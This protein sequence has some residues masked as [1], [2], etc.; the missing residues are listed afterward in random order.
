MHTVTSETIFN[1]Q[2][3]KYLNEIGKCSKCFNQ[4]LK[5]LT[6]DRQ[7]SLMR[8]QLKKSEGIKR[9]R[10]LSGKSKNNFLHS[11][12]HNSIS[13]QLSSRNYD[14]SISKSPHLKSTKSKKKIVSRSKAVSP[15]QPGV[16]TSKIALENYHS[17]ECKGH[18]TSKNS[19]TNTQP[20]QPRQ[21]VAKNG[22]TRNKQFLV[23]TCPTTSL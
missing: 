16:V 6:K 2:E 9:I 17:I 21:N 7:D 5:K 23:E 13:Y 19:P 12:L 14:S 4:I 3:S 11:S 22:G 15:A 18:S 1:N 8:L 10:G 20:K